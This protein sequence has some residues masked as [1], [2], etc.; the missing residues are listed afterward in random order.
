[1]KTNVIG[2]TGEGGRPYAGSTRALTSSVEKE[3][4]RGERREE[5]GERREEKEVRKN[6]FPPLSLSLLSFTTKKKERKKQK[7]K[8]NKKKTNKNKNKN[9]IKNE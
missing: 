1:M 7:K 5:R 6:S 4:E 8:I 9:K 3:R 2:E